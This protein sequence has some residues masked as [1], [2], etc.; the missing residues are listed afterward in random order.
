MEQKLSK[1]AG[2]DLIEE[3]QRLSSKI[4]FGSGDPTTKDPV[5]RTGNA[6][7]TSKISKLRRP[8]FLRRLETSHKKVKKWKHNP[9]SLQVGNSAK[10][11]AQ[12]PKMTLGGR[13]FAK[14]SLRGSN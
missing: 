12:R 3:E 11:N 8:A 2:E 1:R 7:K 13:L 14:N 9:K 5:Q 10:N 4:N 6:K